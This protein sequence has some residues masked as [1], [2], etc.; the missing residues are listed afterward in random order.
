ME[1]VP[2]GQ[3]SAQINMPSQQSKEVSCGSDS[4]AI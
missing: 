4:G 1:I 2:Q 3:E